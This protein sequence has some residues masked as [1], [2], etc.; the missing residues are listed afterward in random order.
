MEGINSQRISLEIK[1][2]LIRNKVSKTEVEKVDFILE[3]FFHYFILALMHG[4]KG[5]IPKLIRFQLAYN[6]FTSIPRILRKTLYF[7][8]KAFGYSFYLIAEAAKLN[9]WGYT[10]RTDKKLLKSIANHNES[11]IIYKLLKK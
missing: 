5:V 9:Y 10:F 11:D 4:A 8:S 7:S 6:Y 2:S 3:R 1:K